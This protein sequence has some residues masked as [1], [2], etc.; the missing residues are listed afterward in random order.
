METK[1]IGF[2]V[3]VWIVLLFVSATFE[4][5]T[6]AAGTWEGTAEASKL[7]YITN[8]KHVT[9]DDAETGKLAW[10]SPNPLYFINL[11]SVVGWDFTF[12]DCPEDD[13]AT[14]DVN[15]ARCPYQIIRWVFLV[16]F[17]VVALFGL[18]YMFITLLQGFIH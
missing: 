6:Q 15:E 7:E 9:Y 3:F 8:L 12:L 17:T 2:I 18:S 13:P 1:W 16:P 4:A 5:H 11:V 14:P 10:L